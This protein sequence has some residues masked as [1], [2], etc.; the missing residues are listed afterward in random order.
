MKKLSFWLLIVISAYSMFFGITLYHSLSIL[1]IAT[2]YGYERKLDLDKSQIQK[3][4]PE[5]LELRKKVE[6][7][8]LNY[9]DE[10]INLNRSKQN[11]QNTGKGLG[12]GFV[13]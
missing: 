13:F 4:D 10:R 2:L 9:Q 8:Q 6:V 5:L 7:N 12:S 1:F 11:D 3:I